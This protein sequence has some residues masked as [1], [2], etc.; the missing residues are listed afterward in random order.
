MDPILRSDPG[1]GVVVLRL[2][3]GD[4]NVLSP[5]LMV[6]L[7]SHLGDLEVDPP[8]TLVLEGGEANF[9]SGGFDLKALVR[10][11]RR[12]MAYFLRTFSETLARIIELPA[13][14]LCCVNGHAIGGGFILPLACDLRVV[15]D[16]DFRLGLNEVNLAA[17]VGAGAQLLLSARTS[18]GASMRLSLFGTPISPAEVADLGYADVLT[19]E[20]RVDVLELAQTLATKPGTGASAT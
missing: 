6:M 2:N 16:G 8:R 12:E 13:P 15:Q 1:D 17:P 9:F 5:D 3:N 14:T 7:D 4:D 11:G 18:P 19:D 20:A 10:F